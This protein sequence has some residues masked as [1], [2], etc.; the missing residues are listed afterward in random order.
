MKLLALALT[1]FIFG[2]TA[3]ASTQSLGELAKKEKERRQ[4]LTKKKKV[5]QFNDRHL[6]RV[7]FGRPAIYP[8]EAAQGDEESGGSAREA[9]VA[10][11]DSSKDETDGNL[12]LASLSEQTSLESRKDVEFTKAVGAQPPAD[13]GARR[14]ST[15]GT[16]FQM[17]NRLPASNFH[18][19]GALYA[20]L[21]RATY[22]DGLSTSQLSTRAKFEMGRRP[23]EGWRL[24][25]DVRDKFN[26]GARNANRLIVYD[27][28][29]IYEDQASPVE[30]SV[31][32]MNLYNSA[33]VGQLLGGVLG[34][35][36][37]P[38][39]TAGGYP[40][41]QADIYDL[42]VDLQYQK[43]GVYTQYRG[44]GAK[45]AALSYN[46]IR[47]E[48]RG[49]RVFI[50]ASGLF[51]IANLAVL[52]GNMEYEVG[53]Y[54]AQK[55]RL[56]RV[57][58]NARYDP[59]T[60]VQL[61]AY[62][63]SGKGLDFHRFLLEQSQNPARNSPEL[64]R[65]YYSKTFGARVTF[66]PHRRVRLYL[67]KRESEQKDRMIR[68]HTT[69]LGGSAWNIGGSGISLYGSYNINRG[70]ASESDSYRISMSRDFGPL[71]WTAYYST[72]FNGIRFNAVTGRPSI[73]RISDRS[74]VSNDFFFSISTALALSLVHDYSSRGVQDENTL[75]FRVIYRF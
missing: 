64:E 69:Q 35:Q 65:F 39:I 29:V 7:H 21:F 63:S 73:V 18:L 75:F 40:G 30:L 11:D 12:V 56:S 8:G 15:T 47:F 28:R 74:T 55:D 71:S 4:N 25:F 59:T 17:P 72:T 13:S 10:S 36:I 57:F 61:S 32:Q 46:A 43:Y 3:T 14:I 66:K 51:P 45:S 42:N 23:G 49:E 33:G 26:N 9:Q 68:N 58:L 19:R 6:G 34:Y 1:I 24:F 70:D 67:A 31:G 37:N 54:L 20:D 53:D 48:G 60:L 2:G 62:Y 16:Q 5:H 44:T 52:Y 38:P 41:L 22:N 27:A 50:Y